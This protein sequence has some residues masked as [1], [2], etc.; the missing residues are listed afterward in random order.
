MSLSPLGTATAN[1]NTLKIA[2]KTAFEAKGPLYTTGNVIQRLFI[3]DLYTQ[4]TIYRYR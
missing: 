2:Q 3:I 4:L 1:S